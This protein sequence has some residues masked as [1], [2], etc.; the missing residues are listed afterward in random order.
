MLCAVFF[1]FVYDVTLL[2]M[3]GVNETVKPYTDI[4]SAMHM[5]GIATGAF[6]GAAVLIALYK[7]AEDK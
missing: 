3:F 7:Q 5:M 6:E 4:F 2:G 1:I